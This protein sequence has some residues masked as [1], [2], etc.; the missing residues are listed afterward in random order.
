MKAYTF[1]HWHEFEGMVWF[2]PGFIAQ[3]PDEF[4][5]GRALQ[6][7]SSLAEMQGKAHRDRPQTMTVSDLK[8]VIITLSTADIVSD[9]YMIR[10]YFSQGLNVNAFSMLAM[11][12]TN[13]LVQLLTMLAQYK[14]K[15]WATKLKEGLITVL[16]L[17]PFVDCY[18][19]H[20]GHV[21]EEDTFSALSMMYFN[22]GIEVATEGIPGCVLQC[23]VLFLNPS[24]R[25]DWGAIAS[26]FV[27]GE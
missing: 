22:K 6:Q 21:D 13:A 26:I 8:E 9:I 27:S 2:T 14:K 17:R 3:I 15:S 24:L 10:L 7:L 18:R 4:I 16:F 5:P 1:A 20:V 23:Y 11:I 12:S 25:S 19:V